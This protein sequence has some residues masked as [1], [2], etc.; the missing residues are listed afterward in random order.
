MNCQKSVGV[1]EAG[2]DGQGDR[3]QREYVSR[4]VAGYASLTAGRTC[5]HSAR[6]GGGGGGG[7]QEPGR[8]GGGQGG[9]KGNG[10]F[11]RA[12]LGVIGD[13]RAPPR[14]TGERSARAGEL[15]CQ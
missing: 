3:R 8:R 7:P 14:R 2:R 13:R 6:R 15:K 10:C 4:R 5:G 11:K 1:R 9:G 12:V